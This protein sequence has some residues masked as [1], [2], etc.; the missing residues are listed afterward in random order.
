MKLTIIIALL[1]LPYAFVAQNFKHEQYNQST[2]DQGVPTLPTDA[3]ITDLIAQLDS[4]F[5]L[6]P[7]HAVTKRDAKL[8][9]EIAIAFYNREMYDAADWYLARVK[10]YVDIQQPEPEKII[11]LPTENRLPEH[12][13][14]NELRNLQADVKFLESLPDSYEQLS[15]TQLKQIAASIQTRITRLIAEKDSLIQNH[16]NQDVIKSKRE[17][18]QTLKKEKEVIDITIDHDR[19]KRETTILKLERGDLR[20]YLIVI[21]I[22]SA[23]LL[24]AIAVVIQRKSINRKTQ[25]LSK[26]QNKMTEYEQFVDQSVL[27]S[28]ADAFGK[29]TYV[30]KK[31]QQVSG[32][33][34]KEAIGQDHRIVN[35]GTHPKEFWEEMY[36]TTVGKKQV[37]NQIVTNKNKRGELY[38]V[39]SYIKADFSDRG[40]LLGF[41]S[42]RYDVTDVV[43]NAQE[44]D[45]KNT[46][47]EHA[48]KILRHDM[49]SG[50]NTYIPR[51]LSSLERR[52]TPEDVRR[53]KLDA[54]LKMI[55]EGLTH[56][57]RVYKGVYEFT[58]LVKKDVV[59]N[60]TECDIKQIL[61]AYLNSTSYK[62]QVVIEDTGVADV[63]E[64]LFCTAVDNLIRNGLKY[65]DSPTKFVKIFIED[66]DLVIQDNGRGL[67]QEEFDHL[68][69]PYVRKPGQTETGSGLG[70]NICVAILTEHG[71]GISCDKNEIG[72]KIKIKLGNNND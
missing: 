16:G 25:E 68:S 67:S 66:G 12:V 50:I 53:L 23:I 20:T 6:F 49:H 64:A 38:W 72:T 15:Q 29:I 32:W 10:G 35:S 28:K 5:L 71:F 56:T 22:I 43:K 3:Y 42:I 17:S 37:W 41:T 65:N 14:V 13:T 36:R 59:L 31:F 30:N 58:N 52:L 33:T 45:K 57:Q 4:E 1:L 70:L 46:Y 51:G 48:A 40:K 18:I 60:K 62:S 9:R 8:C 69:K 47:L 19:L 24:L 54:P 34:L 2:W 27:V 7:N 63:N 26:Q 39:D 21:S 11:A 61:E 44:I 55:R